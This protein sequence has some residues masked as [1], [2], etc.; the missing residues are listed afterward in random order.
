VTRGQEFAA[1]SPTFAAIGEAG[2]KAMRA[3]SQIQWYRV[4]WSA[5]QGGGFVPERYSWG[6]THV[7]GRLDASG[8]PLAQWQPKPFPGW[9]RTKN[10]VPD[11]FNSDQ[12]MDLREGGYADGLRASAPKTYGGNFKWVQRLDHEPPNW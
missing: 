2:F 4:E 6:G 10:L 8:N 12:M 5:L 3:A 9:D 7:M 1:D 11:E